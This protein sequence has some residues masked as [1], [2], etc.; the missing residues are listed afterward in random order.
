MEMEME[1]G[2]V[3]AEAGIWGRCVYCIGVRYSGSG[4]LLS[5]VEG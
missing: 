1:M 3:G 4:P 5:R 2:W